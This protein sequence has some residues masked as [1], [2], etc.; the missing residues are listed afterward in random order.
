MTVA[1]TTEAPLNWLEIRRTRPDWRDILYSESLRVLEARA[2][3]FESLSTLHAHGVY[4]KIERKYALPLMKAYLE[5]KQ[6]PKDWMSAGFHPGVWCALFNPHNTY[7]MASDLFVL[8]ITF[9]A[10]YRVF[11]PENAEH[12]KIWSVWITSKENQEKTNRWT[13]EK[14][15]SGSS[16]STRLKDGMVFPFCTPPL[17]LS[18]A[19]PYHAKFYEEHRFGAFVGRSD[20]MGLVVVLTECIEKL[21][22]VKF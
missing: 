10:D 16:L 22:E 17:V 19:V 21:E 15:S 7:S 3:C 12:R 1:A 5:T 8:K 9:K 11:D 6:V 2:S 13:E 4:H 14:N 20:Y 18:P